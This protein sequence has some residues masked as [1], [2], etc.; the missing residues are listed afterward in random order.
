MALETLLSQRIVHILIEQ[1][2]FTF[3]HYLRHGN[4]EDLALLESMVPRVAFGQR[5]AGLDTERL[6]TAVNM[7]FVEEYYQHH[8][9][10]VSAYF[11]DKPVFPV[12]EDQDGGPLAPA[13]AYTPW[14]RLPADT[15]DIRIVSMEYEPHERPRDIM[16]A[17]YF[18][19][20]IDTI[21][22]QIPGVVAANEDSPVFN[23]ALHALLDLGIN[24]QISDAKEIATM[25]ESSYPERP[26]TTAHYKEAYLR[27]LQD[28]Q[29]QPY[30]GMHL[31]YP[32]KEDPDL[33]AKYQIIRAFR[34]FQEFHKATYQEQR[35]LAKTLTSQ[36]T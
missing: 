5:P 3:P 31:S 33:L 11:K 7:G 2:Q 25:L 19:M 12:P 17:R 14:L 34:P 30:L 21:Q 1:Q 10:D 26:I 22:Q 35:V 9:V 6:L 16:Q 18:S 29:L 28:E 24:R 32:D 27:I 20:L 8:Q 36:A 13:G 15:R 23:D 4:K